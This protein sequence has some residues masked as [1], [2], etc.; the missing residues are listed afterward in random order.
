M[1]YNKRDMDNILPVAELEQ[2]INFNNVPYFA[3]SAIDGTGVIET[4]TACCKL[5]FKQM[6][7]SGGAKKRRRQR[8]EETAA[9]AP[10]PTSTPPKAAEPPI[11]AP[12]EPSSAPLSFDDDD[13]PVIRIIADD[14]FSPSEKTPAANS[15]PSLSSFDRAAAETQVHSRVPGTSALDDMPVMDLMPEGDSAQAEVPDDESVPSLDALKS[16]VTLPDAAPFELPGTTK[17]DR[18]DVARTLPLSGAAAGTPQTPDSGS[19]FPDVAKEKAAP[20]AASFTLEECG[21]P[22]KITNKAINVPLTFKDPQ[23]GRMCTVMVTVSFDD[24]SIS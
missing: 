4:L 18:E 20:L 13:G 14:D 17:T 24:F 10:L 23:T 12:P 11:T 22:Q 21:A 3:A 6:D 15:E 2:K 8:Q 19:N 16:A 5:V 7:S 1:Q 9:P